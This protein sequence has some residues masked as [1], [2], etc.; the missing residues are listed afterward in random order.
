MSDLE[1][2]S[3]IYLYDEPTTSNL[4]L[5]KIEEYLTKYITHVEVFKR[6]DFFN[7]CLGDTPTDDIIQKL[8]TSLA[9]TKVRD[10]MDPLKTMEPMYG[11]IKFE[12]RSL[13]DPRSTVP[14]ILY[15]GFKLHNLFQNLLNTDEVSRDTIHIIFTPR[16]FGT[17]DQN[18]RRYH[19]RDIICGYPS[20]ISTAG[21]VE[22]PA[23]PKEYYQIKHSL[24]AQNI[25]T[26]D[27]FVHDD[28][29]KRYLKYNDLRI[30]EVLKGYAMQAVFFHFT[31]DPFCKDPNCKLFNAHWQEELLNAQ[32]KE[33]EFC[34]KHHNILNDLK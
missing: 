10:I 9:G 33:P 17:F 6:D 3:K 27:E 14:G 22:A 2:L 34:E 31:G 8:G 29:K 28:I 12:E 5:P 19:V 30:T 32:L 13:R 16:L 4:K 20:L 11:E 25:T 26:I 23:K 18:D 1:K 24:L 7:Y 21:I 15:D